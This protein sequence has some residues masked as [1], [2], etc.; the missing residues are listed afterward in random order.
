MSQKNQLL[1]VVMISMWVGAVVLNFPQRNLSR[2][3]KKASPAVVWIGAE[4][5]WSGDLKW[6]GSGFFVTPNL[7]A[8]AGH[9]VKD[10]ESF[11]VMFSDGT[12]AKADFVYAENIDR[13]DVGFI[14]IRS[15][16][17]RKKRPYFDLNTDVEAGESAV[18]LGYPWGSNTTMSITSGIIAAPKHN[19]WYYLKLSLFVDVA[20]YP[21]NSGSPVLDMDGKVI[22]MLVGGPHQNE[23]YSIC[24]PAKLIELVMQKALAEIGL[25]EIE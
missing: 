19:W 8:T 10:T 23:C 24:T 1:W 13:C 16:G 18:I 20:S 3:Y 25:R 9:V 6:Q 5:N 15:A 12:R 21:G 22:G 4:D 14:Q 2:L 11:E 7:I 17:L